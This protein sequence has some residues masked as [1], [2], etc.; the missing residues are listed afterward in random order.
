MR[1]LSVTGTPSALDGQHSVED[2]LAFPPWDLAIGNM[3][4]EVRDSI[5]LYSVARPV[6][7]FKRLVINAER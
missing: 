5:H 1:P 2:V 4:V 7:S 3:R 6:G